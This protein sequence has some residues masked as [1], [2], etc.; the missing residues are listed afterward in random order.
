G[1]LTTD[2]GLRFTITPAPG[3]PAELVTDRQRLRQILY[4][5]L[6]NAVKFTDRG[7]VGL[8]IDTESQAG[9]GPGI[10]FSVTDTGIG[11]SRHS[12]TSIFS[13]FQQGDGTTS[14]RYAGTGLGLAICREVATQL[15]GEVTVHSELGKGST[16]S[17]YLPLLGQT[18]PGHAPG[19]AAQAAI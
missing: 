5:L 18:A 4:N 10:G 17:L 15:G 7:H 14:R 8:R 6:S 12:L 13:A 2:K 9:T 1:P 16:F 11:I 19:A 3:V